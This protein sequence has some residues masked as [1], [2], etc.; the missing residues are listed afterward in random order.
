MNCN[1]NN[2]NNIDPNEAT[3]QKRATSQ[4]SFKIFLGSLPPKTTKALVKKTF[5][6]YGK[7]KAIYLQF[8]KKNNFCKGSGYIVLYSESAFNKILSQEISILGRKIFK[9][10]FLRGK[11][12][13]KKKKE[14]SSKRIFVTDIPLEMTDSELKDLFKRFGT[15][16]QA[17][18][19]TCCNGSKQP[20]GFVLFKESESAEKC[21]QKGEFEYNGKKIN[22]R[23]FE[24]KDGKCEG[25]DLEEGIKAEIKVV[26]EYVRKEEVRKGQNEVEIYQRKSAEKLKFERK[27]SD[28]SNLNFN[29]NEQQNF[30]L[31]FQRSR[32][33]F[34]QKLGNRNVLIH[35]K[36]DP[37]EYL[38]SDLKSKIEENHEIENLKLNKEGSLMERFSLLKNHCEYHHGRRIYY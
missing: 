35:P 33:Y 16:D 14:F 11:K 31:D 20:Y 13:K 26:E 30:N 22:F 6:E 2:A 9:E 4:K 15:V 32:R 19:I 34:D 38:N 37:N 18:R 27:R 10:P 8:N 36:I 1:N 21:H 3:E 7:I 25:V 28:S 5:S 24:S 12:L 29:K 23:F 17:Y